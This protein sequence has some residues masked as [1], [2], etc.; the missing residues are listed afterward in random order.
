M[1]VLKVVRVEVGAQLSK[2]ITN[3]QHPKDQNV[4]GKENAVTKNDTLVLR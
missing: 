4:Y 1:L 3:V 2:E